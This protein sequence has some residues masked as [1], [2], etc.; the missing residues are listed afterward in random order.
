MQEGVPYGVI[1][2]PQCRAELVR[3]YEG[4]EKAADEAVRAIE[5]Q[6]GRDPLSD[7]YRLSSQSDLRLVWV[8]P[9][10]QYPAVAFAFRIV[11][12]QY[13]QNCVM[14]ETRRTNVPNGFS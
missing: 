5:F 1:W 4:D 13:R 14:E 9:R 7:T 6:L 3:L 8:E 2:N 10:M 11:K 12:E